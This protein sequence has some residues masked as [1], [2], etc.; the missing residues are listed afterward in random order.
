[1]ALYTPAVYCWCRRVGLNSADAADVGQEVFQSVARGIAKF[2]HDRPGDSF[3]GW[4]RTITSNK[5]NDFFRAR[6]IQADGGS[7]ANDALRQVAIEPRFGTDDSVHRDRDEEVKLLLHRAVE[8][9]KPEFESRTWLAFWRVAVE[10]Q[11]VATV[12]AELK[13]TPNAVYLAKS[14]VMRRLKTEF[15]GLIDL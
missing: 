11:A 12:A 13:M 8:L 15:A 10:D 3:R 4:L 2:R 9:V 6:G 1:V 5:I 14:R 7:S